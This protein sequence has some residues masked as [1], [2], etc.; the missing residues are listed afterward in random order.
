MKIAGADAKKPEQVRSA[1]DSLDELKLGRLIRDLAFSTKVEQSALHYARRV[2][3][4]RL[5]E[6]AKQT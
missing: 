3:R 1:I 4:R 6:K 5:K 2:L